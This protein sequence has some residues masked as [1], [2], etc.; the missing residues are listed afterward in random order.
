MTDDAAWPLVQHVC[1]TRYADL[2]E[3]DVRAAQ[4][5]KLTSPLRAILDLIEADTVERY[6]IRQA[7][8]QGLDRGLITHEQIR[9]ARMSE[10][11]RNI[12]ESWP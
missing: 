7:L 10:A 8:W 9:N 4:G 12:V 1:R 5:F 11:A 3:S 2:P 6:F